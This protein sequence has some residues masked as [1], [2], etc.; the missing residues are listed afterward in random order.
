[1][2]TMAQLMDAL[3]EPATGDMAALPQGIAHERLEDWA[4]RPVP[5]GAFRR[6][7]VLG[8]MQAEVTAAYMFLW[9]RGWFNNAAENERLHAE[10]QWSTALRVLDSMSYL[11]GA[12]IKIGQ[13][14]AN[15]PDIMPG[16]FVETFERLHF[17]APPMHWSLLK[18]MV[19]NELGDDPEDRFA[20][21]DKRAFA[22]A[23]MGQVHRACL[24]SGE[25]VAVKIQYPGIARTV[26]DDFRNLFFFLLPARFS[27]D[28]ENLRQQFEDLRI[29]LERETDYS[30]E[31]DMQERVRRLFREEDGIVVP[32]VHREHSTGRLLTMDFLPGQTIDEF[33]ARDPSQDER[34]H[35]ARLILR[36]WYRMLYGGRLFYADIHPGNFLLLDDG[37][38]GLIDFGF[39][40]ELDDGAWEQFR[41]IDR[42]Q[43]TGRRDDRLTAMK[44]HNLISD[45]PADE[46][47]LRL[48]EQLC[49]WFWKCRYCRGEFDFGQEAEFRR[50]VELMVQIGRKRYTRGRPYQLVISKQTFGIRSI[51]YRLKA[52]LD[53][54]PLAEADIAMTGWDRSEYANQPN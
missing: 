2:P 40:L 1:M 31:A 34:N 23:S 21:F 52:R 9:L 20:T 53:V 49:D 33:L 45:D 37:R 47:R 11:R 16:P 44:E 8:T 5:V 19:H 29:R 4:L 38:L 18:E 46:E 10:T 36:A 17:D 48:I 13:M 22:A 51:L 26:R 32:R 15:F 41:K 24:K 12:T 7:R 39:M 43:T 27:R 50:G 25:E 14:M 6:L 42:P 54:K 3:P 28:W 35:V 30:Q